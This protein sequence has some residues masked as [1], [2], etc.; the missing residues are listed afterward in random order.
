[1]D[2]LPSKDEKNFQEGNSSSDLKFTSKSDLV[3]G[4]KLLLMTKNTNLSFNFVTIMAA[5]FLEIENV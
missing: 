3:F 2:C 1:M 5:I 4:Q